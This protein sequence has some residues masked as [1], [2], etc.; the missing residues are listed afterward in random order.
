MARPGLARE[1]HLDLKMVGGAYSSEF[2]SDGIRCFDEAMDSLSEKM[3]SL[4]FPLA[5]YTHIDNPR[6]PDGNYNPL[7][8]TV[9]N[10]PKNW[11]RLWHRY[12]RMDPYYHA[13]VNSSYVV[14][15]QK[16]RAV[17]ELCDVQHEACHYLDDV[18]ISQGITVPIHHHGGGFTAVSAICATSETDWPLMFRQVSEQVFV[19]AHR[20]HDKYYGLYASE[21][22]EKQAS[23][24]SARESEVIRWV[25]HGKTVPEIATILE[26][27]PETIKF[28]VKNAY[29]KL[30][31]RNRGHA[32]SQAAR[33]GL[34]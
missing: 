6:R 30:G 20:F 13:A 29:A 17:D 23:P 31:A 26:R 18:G 27:S 11:D 15:W 9:R 4:G 3:S 14:D 21:N 19:T 7:P 22:G 8:L 34:L 12:S 25:A 33:L 2:P 1:R 24:L 28:H 32:V 10:F 5:L 16:V